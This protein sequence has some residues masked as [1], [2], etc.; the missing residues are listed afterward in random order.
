MTAVLNGINRHEIQ[1]GRYVLTGQMALR[2]ALGRE[3]DSSASSLPEPRRRENVQQP[4][5][6]GDPGAA[7]PLAVLRG[8]REVQQAGAPGDHRGQDSEGRGE[9]AAPGAPRRPPPPAASADRWRGLR[10]PR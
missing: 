3:G 10:S 5:H 7:A 4:R 8:R 6:H 1:T 2:D 9:R